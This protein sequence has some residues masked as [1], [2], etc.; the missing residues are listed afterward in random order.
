MAN[1]KVGDSVRAFGRDEVGTI[2]KLNID[3][4]GT[5]RVAY[6]PRPETTTL[7]FYP[8]AHLDLVEEPK[9]T[10]T[11][12]AGEGEGAAAP[13]P[14]TLSKKTAKAGGGAATASSPPVS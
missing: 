1:L 14:A 6:K 10:N 13:A 12:P 4:Y 5:A 8:S 2:E 11:A 9:G 3:G 7:G